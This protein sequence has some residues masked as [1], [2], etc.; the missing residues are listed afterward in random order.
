MGMA[1]DAPSMESQPIS[2]RSGALVRP[3][4][5]RRPQLLER[6][7]TETAAEHADIER[8]AGILHPRLEL[9]Q[10]RMYLERTLGFYL[11]AEHE[12]WRRGVWDALGLPAME[13]EKLP[14]LA[15]D[16]VLLGNIAPE[17]IAPCPDGP[18]FSSTA[19]A[20]GGAY[21]LEGS[22]LG[23]RVISRHIQRLFGPDVPRSFLECYGASTGEQWQSF[24]AALTRYARTRELADQVIAGAREMFRTFTAWLRAA[25]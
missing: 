19:E 9:E 8:A 6:L 5:V 14:I 3:R 11:V 2:S 4:A 25:R 18:S 16:I 17:S 23:G 12:L 7:K 13:R 21:V 24:R 10:Y 15:E 20:V 1:N 22:T